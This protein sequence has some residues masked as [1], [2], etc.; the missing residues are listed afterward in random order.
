M[1]FLRSSKDFEETCHDAGHAESALQITP[2]LEMRF[3]SQTAF[4]KHK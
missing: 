1:V 2:S 3:F 4:Y